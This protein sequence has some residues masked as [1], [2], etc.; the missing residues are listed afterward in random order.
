MTIAGYRRISDVRSASELI[1][2]I[3]GEGG[4]LPLIAER[5][6]SPKG[7][8]NSHKR[9]NIRLL[10]Y[11]AE[12]FSAVDSGLSAFLAYIKDLKGVNIDV[13]QAN[14]N[15][16]TVG[17]VRLMTFHA[18]K[19]LEFPVCFVARVNQECNFREGGG[20]ARKPPLMRFDKVAG[21]V[22]DN[23]DFDNLCRFK[24]LHSDYANRLNRELTIEEEMRKL[25]VA[26]TR[27]EYK[28]I[29]TGFST[30]GRVKSG[31]YAEWLEDN[32]QYTVENF[33][34][35]V[36]SVE[37]IE[38]AES[39]EDIKSAE[40]IKIAADEITANINAV[41]SRA[42][43]GTIPRKL[44]A[45]QVAE[46]FGG[47]SGN[48]HDEPTIFPRNPSF[49]GE[50]RLT[51]KKRGDAYHKARELIEFGGNGYAEQLKRLEHRFTPLEYKAVN[52]CDIVG[53]FE[54]DLG[55][56]AVNSE[57]VCKEYELYTEIGLVELGV[58]IESLPTAATA[59]VKPPAV[60]QSPPHLGSCSAFIQ[61]IADM[62][63]YEDGEIVLVDY[64][65]NRGVAAEKLAQ[66]Y[67]GQ[68]S[69]YKKAI[70]EM[71]GGK[72]K[73]CWIYSFEQGAILL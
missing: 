57:K 67:R 58:S 13:R 30:G 32:I 29:F 55:K 56:R 43:L 39:T 9:A 19:G 14:P 69:V 47:L 21:I 52:P 6:I 60:G 40:S 53:F 20:V 35:S 10:S 18:A 27:A 11:Y 1:A 25:Y 8:N 22:A 62:F 16:Q 23:F 4:F 15:S 63:F 12:K 34:E 61:G 3:N 38:N 70:E 45:T 66:D 26:A 44:T 28:L 24:T 41:Y 72:V 49:R 68:L 59:N 51:G 5:E 65:T 64:K 50:G 17:S 36:E 37:S 2:V 7:G 54:S 73:E 31:S 48:E 42:V 33:V 46:G 71:T